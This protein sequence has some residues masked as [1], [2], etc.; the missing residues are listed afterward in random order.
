LSVLALP[1]RQLH[2]SSFWLEKGS[3]ALVGVLGL[4]LC[5]RAVKKLRGLLRKPTFTA[6]TPI[7]SIMNTA[8][9]GISICP[10]RNSY[11]RATTGA[12]V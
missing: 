11:S 1:A 4:L 6:F 3:Y 8:G 9:V 10:R 7:M 2:L 12:R 5:W